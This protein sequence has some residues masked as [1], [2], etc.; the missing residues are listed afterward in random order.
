MEVR[1][2]AASEALARFDQV[3]ALYDAVGWSNYTNH[4]RMLRAALEGSLALWAAFEGTSEGVDKLIGLVRVV[5][6]GASIVFVQDLLVL[7]EFQRQGAGTQLLRC[8]LERYAHV[9][10][11]E[12]LTDDA[13][14]TRAF[15]ESLGFAA[16]D[17]MGCRSFVRVGEAP[18]Q[19]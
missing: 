3:I 10:Q 18:G 12:L 4:P 1:E 6:D 17:T 8:V 16:A 11:M 5:G 7:P 15:Y 9:Y 13:E 19:A 2:L 14:K